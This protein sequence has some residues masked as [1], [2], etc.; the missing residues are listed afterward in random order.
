MFE[1]RSYLEKLADVWVYPRFLDQAAHAQDPVERM[2][3]VVTW[4]VYDCK[5]GCCQPIP[6]SLRDRQLTALCSCRF[7]AG[8]QHAFQS[9]RKPFNPILGET[10]E[11][12]LDDG[13]QIYM[14]QISHH[15]PISAFQM[16]GPGGP[17]CH[18]RCSARAGC[19]YT[20][21]CVRSAAPEQGLGRLEMHGSLE[22]RQPSYDK[23][24]LCLSGSSA[25]ARLAH[26]HLS[27]CTWGRCSWQHA[28]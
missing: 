19:V 11:A 24:M 26:E 13:S 25:E 3:L 20:R 4:C 16:F 28:M 18:G 15:P 23:A 12:G 2:T 14:E 7:L 17:L 1:P 22:A 8:L 5:P 6:G 10:W 21:A 9:W 27:N